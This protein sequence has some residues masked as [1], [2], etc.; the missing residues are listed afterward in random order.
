M[1]EL[2]FNKTLP[3]HFKY[4]E[5]SSYYIVSPQRHILLW[6]ALQYNRNIHNFN[7]DFS[8]SRAILAKLV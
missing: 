1:A 4:K 2:V 7:S 6:A 3:K 8:L 5:M